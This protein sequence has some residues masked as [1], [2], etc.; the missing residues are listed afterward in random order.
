M[1]HQT[2]I[3]AKKNWDTR[4]GAAAPGELPGEYRQNFGSQIAMYRYRQMQCLP[5]TKFRVYR[6]CNLFTEV[7]N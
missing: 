6:I 5:T 3:Q 7:N 1:N 4:L 2:E